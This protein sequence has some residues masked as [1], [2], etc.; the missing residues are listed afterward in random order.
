MR[1]GVELPEMVAT[2]G[3]A[4]RGCGGGKWLRPSLPY[5]PATLTHTHTLTEG[6]G[7]IM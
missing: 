1:V 3:V 4:L 5:A 7:Y 2:E 6:T